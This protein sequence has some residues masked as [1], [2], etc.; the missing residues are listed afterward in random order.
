MISYRVVQYLKYWNADLFRSLSAIL[1][2][3]YS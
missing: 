3:I 2:N 1:S